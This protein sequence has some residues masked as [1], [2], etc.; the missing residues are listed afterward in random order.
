MASL[1]TKDSCGNF[2]SVYATSSGSAETT[3][4]LVHC[5]SDSTKKIKS[6]YKKVYHNTKEGQAMVLNSYLNIADVPEST[7]VIRLTSWCKFP[8]YEAD[9]GFGRPISM[10]PGIIP[11]KNVGC[12]IDDPQ[13]NGVEAYVVLEVKDLP[14]FEE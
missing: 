13:G 11:F 3:E 12:L 10:A 5:V 4:E 6:N 7:N 1:I 8:F 14:Y 2:C 9:F